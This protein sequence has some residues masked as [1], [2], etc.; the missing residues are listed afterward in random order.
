MS[1]VGSASS[2]SALRITGLASGL[3]VDSTVKALMT[4]YNNKLDKMKQQKQLVQWRQDAYRDIISD[5]KS[6]KDTYF[7]QINREKYLLSSASSYSAF[8][9]TATDSVN[10]TGTTSVSATANAGATAGQY[11]VHV[12]QLAQAS[13]ISVNNPT[14][15]STTKLSD[16]GLGVGDITLT[17]DYNTT[18]D[19]VITVNNSSGLKTVGD[20]LTEISSQT[21]GAVIGSFSELTG[22]FT[23]KTSATG[24]TSSIHVDAGATAVALGISNSTGIG[25]QDSILTISPPGVATIGSGTTITKSSN[26]FTV[27]GVTYNLKRTDAVGQYTTLGVSTDTDKTFDKIKDFID[28]YNELVDKIQ[29]KIE[30]KKSLDYQPL[31]DTQKEEMTEDQIEAWEKRAKAGVL[32]N[33]T[34]LDRMLTEMRRAFFDKVESAGI[35]LSEAGLS[36][37]KDTTERG[38]IILTQDSSGE[39]KLKTTIKNNG[40]ALVSLFAKE[41]T[42]QYDINNDSTQ[43]STRYNENGIFQRINDILTSYTTTSLDNNGHRGVLTEKAGIKGTISEYSNS[44]YTDLKNRDK[45]ISAMIDKIADKETQLY[46]RFSALETYLNKMNSQQSYLSQNLSMG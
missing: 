8:N 46:K 12:D 19:K 2:S 3:D 27:D 9:I 23:L 32:R 6:I 5:V 39:Y 38:K 26:S 45:A 41:S 1:S 18:S 4:S 17:L 34:S 36:T 11:L 7:D 10:S 14:F 22:K 15:S 13:T 16:L 44:I 28:K 20:L 25:Q 35:S 40:T 21:S 29:T 37:S 42:T 33:D 24:S 31:T 30:E 43:R